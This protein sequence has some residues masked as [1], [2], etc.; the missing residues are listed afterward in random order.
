[1]AFPNLK[2][3]SS[4]FSTWFILDND[5]EELTH[6]NNTMQIQLIFW[7]LDIFILIYIQASEL[8]I[9]IKQNVF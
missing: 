1:M 6:H 9:N 3:L 8:F 7:Y 2:H 5:F 4:H